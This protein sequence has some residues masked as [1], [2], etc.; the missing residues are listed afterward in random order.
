MGFNNLTC[1][2]EVWTDDPTPTV[3]PD[4][5][6]VPAEADHPALLTCYRAQ[7]PNKGLKKMQWSTLSREF[8]VPKTVL[9]MNKPV[10]PKFVTIKVFGLG[11]K[12]GKAAVTNFQLVRIR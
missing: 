1:L 6:R 12:E 5:W 11:G 4:K 7:L 8:T 9:V 3:K 2:A 10:E